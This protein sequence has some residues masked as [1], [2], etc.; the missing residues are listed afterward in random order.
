MSAVDHETFCRYV[1]EYMPGLYR[2]AYA[3]L[4]NREDAEDAVSESILTAYEKL[5]T[6]RRPECFRAWIMQITANEAKKIYAKNKRTAP[7]DNVEAYM[8]EFYDEYHELWDIVV[9]MEVIYR[10]VVILFYYEQLS[11]KEIGRVLHIPEGTVKS[12]LS[13]AKKQ[14]KKELGPNV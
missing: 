2:L 8:P 9:K 11:V 1:R 3:V 12:R 4:N 7:T 13:R 5:H 6:L 14:L 10:E